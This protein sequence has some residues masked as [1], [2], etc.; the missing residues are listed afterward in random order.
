MQLCRLTDTFSES[1]PIFFRN[2]YMALFK[3]IVVHFYSVPSVVFRPSFKPS[4]HFKIQVAFSELQ[5]VKNQRA[6][7]TAFSVGL[8]LSFTT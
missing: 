6:H 3:Q 7:N 4:S 2:P 8:V 1:R 5:N